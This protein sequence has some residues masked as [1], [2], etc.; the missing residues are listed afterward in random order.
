MFA[1]AQVFSSLISA[2][3][4]FLTVVIT[5]SG[6]VGVALWQLSHDRKERAKDRALQAK[7]EVLIEGVKAAIIARRVIGDLVSVDVDMEKSSSKF[8]EALAQMSAA[9]AVAS[10]EVVT[11]GNEMVAE[12]AKTYMAAMVARTLLGDDPVNADREK[13][14]L[15]SLRGQKELQQP[16][17]RLA[18]AVRRDLLIDGNG[19]AEVAHALWVDVDEAERYTRAMLQALR[20]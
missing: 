14:A 2:W 6:A 12:L 7:R 10:L 5:V 17:A 19:D 1:I 15:A 16:F 3:A 13:F 8:S 20:E 11:R 18:A 4:T 9:T